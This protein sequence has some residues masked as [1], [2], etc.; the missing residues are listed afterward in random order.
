MENNTNDKNINAVN[1]TD[2]LNTVNKNTDKEK[3]KPKHVTTY[4]GDMVKVLEKGEGS[5]IKKIIEAEEQ[6]EVQKKIL[7][8]ESTRNKIFLWVSIILLLVAV[9]GF[10]F[11]YF[12]GQEINIVSLQPEFKPII[13][14][15]K[16]FFI[17]IDDVSDKK[18]IASLFY[19]R[20]LSTDVKIGGIDGIHLTQKGKVVDLKDFFVKIKSNFPEEG[21]QFLDN[22]FVFG[23]FNSEKN[24]KNP[25][26][27]LKTRSFADIFPHMRIWEKRM[28]FDLH[29]FFGVELTPQNSYLQIKEFEDGIVANKNARILYDKAG[30]RV[31]I[32][33]FIDDNSIVIS[34][35]ISSANE[36][37]SRIM[38]S[39]IKK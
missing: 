5:L 28:F 10:V 36:V 18:E 23:V 4:T 35:E 1:N 6:R 21:I 13:F 33:V 34:K 2:I 24:G 37:M 17:N 32:Y 29:D 31:L 3:P 20:V 39:K 22:N 8:P 38:G 11:T 25:F 26:I 19:Q 16:N 27:L 9:S 15:E 7:S 14:T 30:E 12:V